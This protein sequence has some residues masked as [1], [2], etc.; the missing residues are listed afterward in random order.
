MEESNKWKYILIGGTLFLYAA[1]VTLTGVMYGFF[2]TN[3]CSLNQFFVTFNLVLCI[4]IT[5]L[6]VAPAVQDANSR[7]GLAQA[8][9]V[10]IYCTY[11]VLSAVVNEP[12]DKQCN[13]LHRAQGTQT[14]TVVM[15]AIFTF[16]AVAYSTSRAATQGDKLS[17]P[18]REHLLASVE[19]GVMP[20]SALDDDHDELDD[21]QD[22]AMYSYSF[23]HFV[24]AIAA[25]YVAM[26]LT[27]WYVSTAK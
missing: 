20:R 3:G 11:L 19:T 14:T 23:F 18:S 22:G 27:N 4:L 5:L 26:L 1:S 10:V 17:S 8:S 2:A 21:E 12:S 24:F 15:G 7:S 9:I 16:L 13:P 25:M 6:C